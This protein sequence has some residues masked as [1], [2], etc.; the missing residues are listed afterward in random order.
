MIVPRPRLLAWFAAVVLPLAFVASAFHPAAMAALCGIGAF[1]LLAAYD[2][3]ASRG[4]L[5]TVSL[6]LPPLVRLQREREGRIEARIRNI[7]K[8]ARIVRLGLPFPSQL[9][10]GSE[11][12]AIEL[13]ADSEY[14]S[15]TW[16]C[17]PLQRGQYFLKRFYL[18]TASPLG[19]WAVRATGPANCEVRVYPDFLDERKHVAALFL[20]RGHIGIHAR[21]QPGKGRDFEKLRDYVSGDGYD[22][23]HW[24]ASAKR[25]RPVTK[26][27]QVER[28]Q[29]VYV[30]LDASR[31]MARD[32][33]VFESAITAGLLLGVA[34]EQ[35]GDSFGVIAFS[36]RILHFA[37]A[38]NG[39]AQFDVCRDMLYALQPEPV[40]PDFD[41]LA[42]FIR[43][44]LR[45][46]A[47]LVF[48]TALDDPAISESFLH[49][50]DLICRQHLI[51]VNML[52][53]PPA[54]P[55]F[56]DAAVATPGDIYEKLGGHL[57]WHD[58]RE[59]GKVLQRRGVRFSLLEKQTLS[60]RLVTQYIN[61][62]AMQ[63]I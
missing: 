55:L 60:A 18:E 1:A 30:V 47:L 10:A 43:T 21:R 52:R 58:L 28:T 9:I 42:S 13:P 14:S 38:R 7:A 35:Q 51:L 46:R 20:N 40:T 53:P 49:A 25:G 22:E 12:M 15:V 31:L 3:L 2:A 16:V 32:A 8:S 50:I 56:S 24:K 48:L 36:D 37:R 41:E 17:K 44:R 62:K 61:V 54:Q 19:F 27:F 4:S 5:A 63:L 59:L 33:A 23:I 26:V 39:R 11:D 57:L 29:E 34:A 6:E 45:K